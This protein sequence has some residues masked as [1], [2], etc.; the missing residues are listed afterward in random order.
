MDRDTAYEE[1]DKT[2]KTLIYMSEN[3]MKKAPVAH[4]NKRNINSL[5]ILYRR[6]APA[7]L[8]RAKQH[9]SRAG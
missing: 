3:K 9:Q 5:V 8:K 1:L 6:A 2:T 4:M 7:K